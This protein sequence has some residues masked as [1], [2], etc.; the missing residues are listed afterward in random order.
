GAKHTCAV[1]SDQTVRCWGDN[2][3]HQLGHSPL[4]FATSPVAVPNVTGHLVM[5]GGD[6]SC[7]LRTSGV[8]EC[9]GANNAGQLGSTPDDA[10]SATP[11]I[12]PGVVTG[13]TDGGL[14]PHPLA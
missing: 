14:P 10:G 12:V 6:T 8:V 2:S 1:L 4:A 5:L 11:V 9:W 7:N 3:V 13:P